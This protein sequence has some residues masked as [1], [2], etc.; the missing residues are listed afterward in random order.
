MV[1]SYFI[2]C[3]C[4]DFKLG[5]DCNL[6][7]DLSKSKGNNQLVKCKDT[8]MYLHYIYLNTM[9]KPYVNNDTIHENKMRNQ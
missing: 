7:K 4:Y 9:R 3:L 8:E 6:G 5:S 1:S 2:T